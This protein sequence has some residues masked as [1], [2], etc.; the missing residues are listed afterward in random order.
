[1][2]ELTCYLITGLSGAGKSHAL[3]AFEDMG[4]YCVDN[5][6]GELVNSFIN[7]L[8]E[9]EDNPSTAALILDAREKKFVSE[10]PDLV[11]TFEKYGVQLKVVY[12]EASS[13]ELLHRYRESRRPHPL[14]EKENQSLEEAIELEREL[15]SP[16]RERADLVLDTSRINIHQLKGLLIDLCHPEPENKFTLSLL[17]FGFKNGA[18]GHLDFLFDTRF[19]PNPY[20]EAKLKKKTGLDPEIE[21]YMEDISTTGEYLTKLQEF[22]SMVI[23]SYRVTD[24]L[25]ICIGLGC[26]G[27][28]HRSVYFVEKLAEYFQNNENVG[29]SVTHR[30]LEQQK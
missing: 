3:Q 10:F 5:L 30:D 28:R 6:P 7:L 17:S 23:K 19:L 20:Y 18:P 27:G 2:S 21:K 15:L 13:E 12:L 22:I 24:K 16:I 8:L 14:A 9:R 11:E 1:M 26:T 25:G 29:V 4:I